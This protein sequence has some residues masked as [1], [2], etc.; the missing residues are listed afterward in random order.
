MSLS[1]LFASMR[2]LINA[3][4]GRRIVKHNLTILHVARKKV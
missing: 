2:R 3:R 1:R 4:P